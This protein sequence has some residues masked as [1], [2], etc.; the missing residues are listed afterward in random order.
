M[1]AEPTLMTIA[2]L[3]P[4]RMMYMALASHFEQKLAG[5]H[6]MPRPAST[7]PGQIG[8]TGNS[9]CGYGGD[10]SKRSVQR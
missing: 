10:A 9:N 4:V 2:V 7:P 1:A 6:S 5:G 8:N 3:M